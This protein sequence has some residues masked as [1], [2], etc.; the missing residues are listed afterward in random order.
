MGTYSFLKGTIAVKQTSCKL[1][2]RA[3]CKAI[4]RAMMVRLPFGSVLFPLLNSHSTGLGVC[5]GF[6]S[7]GRPYWPSYCRHAINSK[8]N[9]ANPRPIECVLIFILRFFL[10]AVCCWWMGLGKALHCLICNL[11]FFNVDLLVICF[12]FEWQWL[13][14]WISRVAL[15]TMVARFIHQGPVCLFARPLAGN[16]GVRV[17]LVWLHCRWWVVRSSDC[18]RQCQYYYASQPVGSMQIACTISNLSSHELKF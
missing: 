3:K 18:N 15:L 17:L 2:G 5:F 14:Y 10:A 8:V 13:V 11:L 12:A 7:Y 16:K 4:R 9:K 1:V 6:G